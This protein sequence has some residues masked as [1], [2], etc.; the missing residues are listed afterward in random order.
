MSFNVNT[1]FGSSLIIWDFWT[2]KTYWV[3]NIVYMA[4]EKWKDDV[5]IISNIPNAITDIHYNSPDDLRQVLEYMFRFF[6]ETN[7]NI[8][9]YN[10]IF[11][12]IILVIDEAQSSPSKSET[13]QPHL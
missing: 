13:P 1:T 8:E 11:R 5:C 4:K 7:I 10:K 3:E 2:W 9:K 12:D 6:I